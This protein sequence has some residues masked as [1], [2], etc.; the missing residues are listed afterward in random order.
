MWPGRRHDEFNPPPL[1]GAGRLNWPIIFMAFLALLAATGWAM[2]H[3]WLKYLWPG[4]GQRTEPPP[5]TVAP[6]P[7]L[8]ASA[9]PGYQVTAPPQPVT[10]EPEVMLNIGDDAE[11]LELRAKVK[12]LEA[13]QQSPP[14]PPPVPTVAA[15]P[16]PPEETAEQ[17]RQRQRERERELKAWKPGSGQLA[18]A[19]EDKGMRLRELKTPWSL[20]P[21][22]LINC[23]TEPLLSN[24][25][26]GMFRAM[27]T[28]A[29]K[30]V[31][32]R[33]VVI[34]QGSWLL[35]DA[36]GQL[37]FGDTRI[38]VKAVLLRFPDGS[39]LP[40]QKA[41]VSDRA[42]TAGVSDLV[43]R[44]YGRLLMSIILTGVLRGGSSVVAGGMGYGLGGQDPAEAIGGAIASETA[45]RGGDQV[46]QVL[47]TDPT[48]KVRQSYGCSLMLHEALD[49]P[50]PY[51]S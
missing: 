14:Q 29:V 23:R 3:D 11:L 43:D 17:R 7:P 31:R 46:R 28:E 42:G 24:E 15:A 20:P 30:D 12:R 2:S 50:G 25:S 6:V 21:T 39:H 22:W 32:G 5:K 1:E 19:E 16:K 13:A 36:S 47:R 48:V 45:Q 27:V 34:P 18:R 49:L 51:P 10:P 33:H 37:L 9:P 4:W 26:P 8:P 38:P 41:G 40:L 35:L 44:H